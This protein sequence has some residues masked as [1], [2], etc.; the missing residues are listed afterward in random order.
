MRV[1]I[2]ESFDQN[3]L[4]VVECLQLEI[5]FTKVLSEVEKPLILVDLSLIVFNCPAVV[6]RHHKGLSYFPNKYSIFALTLKS[7][8]IV[9]DSLFWFLNVHKSSCH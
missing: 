8:L 5:E 2:F 7:F 4:G 9:L 1:K 6:V 3:S